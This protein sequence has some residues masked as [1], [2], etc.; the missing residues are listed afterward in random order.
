MIYAGNGVN[1]NAKDRDGNTPLHLAI[2]HGLSDLAVKL[3]DKKGVRLDIEN[4]NGETALQL[5]HQH[6][7]ES[8][9]RENK[10]GLA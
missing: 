1:L 8:W 6:Y 7:K 5:Y 9:P 10:H 2:I 4:H 3:I